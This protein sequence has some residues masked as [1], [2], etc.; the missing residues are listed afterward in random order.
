MLILALLILVISVSFLSFRKG[1]QAKYW[2]TQAKS[3]LEDKAKQI[4]A[5]NVIKAEIE[6]YQSKIA[7]YE[8]KLK[9]M[10]VSDIWILRDSPPKTH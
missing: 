6:L 7:D 8:T 10:A 5:Q 1:Q 4:A 2:E 9:N 3:A